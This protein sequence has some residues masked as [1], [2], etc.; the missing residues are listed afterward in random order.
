MEVAEKPCTRV[1]MESNATAASFRRGMHGVAM[2]ARSS[3]GTVDSELRQ[4]WSAR[5]RH[6]HL[7]GTGK[8]LFMRL[9]HGAIINSGTRPVT[10]VVI[11]INA[12][13]RVLRVLKYGID[14]RLQVLNLGNLVSIRLVLG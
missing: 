14:N 1:H 11:D 6:V 13:T 10:R 2:V 8:V 5:L 4:R 7:T 9:P 12:R 3:S